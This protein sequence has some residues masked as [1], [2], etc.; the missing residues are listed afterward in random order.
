[1]WKTDIGGKEEKYDKYKNLTRFMK[2][3]KDKRD[4]FSYSNKSIFKNFLLVV[5][6]V[7][8]TEGETAETVQT[9]FDFVSPR[10]MVPGD[11]AD[12]STSM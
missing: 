6:G 1:M 3:V 5:D 9:Q 4:A 10:R 7:M 2:N 12:E 8:P 11:W